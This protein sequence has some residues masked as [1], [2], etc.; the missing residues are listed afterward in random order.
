MLSKNQMQDASPKVG[1][2]VF[3]PIGA[4]R[5]QA[6]TSIIQAADWRC[7]PSLCRRSAAL[8][9]FKSVTTACGAKPT[10]QPH[11]RSQLTHARKSVFES[12]IWLKKSA[13]P[14][15]HPLAFRG[16]VNP[17]KRNSMA[18]RPNIVSS[19][20]EL[21]AS[22]SS[23]RTRIFDRDLLNEHRAGASAP[24]TRPV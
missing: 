12:L 13:P 22:A 15:K 5:F 14:E 4:H 6:T 8:Q 24:S 23:L 16:I 7:K 9:R 11:P 18:S 2:S 20:D 3:S 19:L 1:S 17:Q 21:A 10:L